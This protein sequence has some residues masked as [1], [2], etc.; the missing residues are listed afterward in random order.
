MRQ[1]AA[2]AATFQAPSGPV[3]MPPATG[4]ASGS[5][6]TMEG[7]APGVVVAPGVATATWLAGTP[8]RTGWPDRPGAGVPVA[9]MA[10]RVPCCT[11][12]LGT[13]CNCAGAPIVL[14]LAVLDP[15]D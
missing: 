8:P 3:L 10:G 9:P 7:V 13:A 11:V 5:S 14:R 2:P 12:E 6:E 1:V 15:V 4:W